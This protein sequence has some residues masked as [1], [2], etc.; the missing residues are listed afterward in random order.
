MITYTSASSE[1]IAASLVTQISSLSNS[2]TATAVRANMADLSAATTI[3]DAS[4]AAFGPHI[5]ILVNNAAVQ[6]T[7]A[8]K[9][10]SV[11]DITGVYDVNIRG[12]ILL[13]QAVLKHLRR[14][15]RI[16]NI[17]SVGA[18]QGFAEL[19][20][21]CSSKAA[22]EGLTRSWAGEL[23]GVSAF[24]FPG[25]SGLGWG[26]LMC[27]EQDGTTVNAVAPGP[28]Q[29]EMLESIPP[30]IVKSQKESTPVQQRVG[31]PEEVS[32][33][34]CWLASAEASWVS[35]QVQNVSG[36]WSMP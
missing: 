11:E 13:T 17:S 1:S 31:M 9:D 10:I 34:V 5:D 29:S 35:G 15:G 18:R 28:V 22:L 24:R 12:V 20:L 21:Y 27:G 2:A 30:Q 36:G 14:P 7:R 6:T 32:N 16:I 26:M 25:C 3:V 4:L 8:L 23:G 19:S 33:V